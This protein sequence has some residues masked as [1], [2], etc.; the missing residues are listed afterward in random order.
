M[1][2]NRSVTEKGIIR[3]VRGGKNGFTSKRVYG[4]CKIKNSKQ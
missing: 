3:S 2:S 1:G 4:V